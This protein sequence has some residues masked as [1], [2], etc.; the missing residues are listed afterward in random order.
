MPGGCSTVRRA[1]HAQ[2]VGGQIPPNI[3]ALYT[4]SAPTRRICFEIWGNQTEGLLT[5]TKKTEDRPG[6]G[7]ARAGAG[8]PKKHP[9]PEPT[10]IFYAD[11]EAYLAAVVEGREP[12]DPLRIA[13]AKALMAYQKPKQRKPVASPSARQMAA[14]AVLNAEAEFAARAA[15][16]RA[17]HRKE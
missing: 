7:G 1:I 9:T 13:A 11:A 2:G 6:R 12:P 15:A 16:V 10:G 14:S 4:A 8:R 3:E 5:M 17:K